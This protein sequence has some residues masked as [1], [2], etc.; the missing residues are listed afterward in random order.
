MRVIKSGTGFEVYL[1]DELMGVYDA[2]LLDYELLMGEGHIDA[3]LF[4]PDTVPRTSLKGVVRNRIKLPEK[5]QYRVL[6]V[7]SL[8]PL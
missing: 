4:N 5:P 6:Y 2:V 3:Y 1:E 7:Y 8:P